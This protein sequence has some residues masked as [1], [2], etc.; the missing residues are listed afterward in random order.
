MHSL[1]LHLR[2]KRVVVVEGVGGGGIGV[3]FYLGLPST[4]NRERV[5]NQG[6]KGYGKSEIED[7]KKENS[8]KGGDLDATIAYDASCS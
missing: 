7:L 4:C 2:G 8:N 5:C 1:I 3:R 6:N